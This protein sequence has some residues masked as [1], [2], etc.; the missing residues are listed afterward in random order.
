MLTSTALSVFVKEDFS[1]CSLAHAN[2]VR[3][4]HIGM[5]VN[6][7]SRKDAY[8]DILGTISTTVVSYL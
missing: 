8:R 6:V 2:N 1:K 4:V 7:Q 3:Q 5:G